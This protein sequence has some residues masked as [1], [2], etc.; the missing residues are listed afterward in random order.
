MGERC[1]DRGW[2]DGQIPPLFDRTLPAFGPMFKNKE[3]Y[4][5]FG[6]SNF[7]FFHKMFN[8]YPVLVILLLFQ[9]GI[10]DSLV[11]AML[12]SGWM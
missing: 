6:M 10:P 4:H 1:V 5:K 12:D 2:P 3:I 11:L 7:F 9:I 8:S